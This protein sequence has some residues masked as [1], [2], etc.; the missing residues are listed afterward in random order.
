MIG[1]IMMECEGYTLHRNK[2]YIFYFVC[3]S[4]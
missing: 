2:F 3:M 1:A 4:E